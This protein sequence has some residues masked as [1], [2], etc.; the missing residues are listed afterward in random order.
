MFFGREKLVAF[1][2][3]VLDHRSPIV[4][5]HGQRRI[6]KS[7][8]LRQIP[9]KLASDKLSFISF[10]LQDLA[11]SPLSRVLHD[12]AAQVAKQLCLSGA[13]EEPTRA[14]LDRDPSIFA[15]VFLP[16]V[17]KACPDRILVLLLDEFDVLAS[18]S[19]EEAGQHFFPYL[20]TIA[21]KKIVH[22]VAVVGR[23][24]DEVPQL[25]S[26]FNEAPHQ[27]IGLLDDAGARRLIVEPARGVLQYQDD[28]IEAILALSGGH[29]YF[30]QLMCHTVFAAARARDATTVTSS[31]VASAV[32]EALESGEAGLTW[33]RD[34][35]P[36]PERVMFAAACEAQER[37][38]LSEDTVWT[39][40]M[41]LGIVR[42]PE[43]ASALPRLREWKF[44][45]SDTQG[46]L[47]A[48]RSAA[49]TYRV[50]VELVRRWMVKRHPTRWEVAQ[51]ADLHPEHARLVEEAAAK[52]DSDPDTAADLLRQCLKLNPNHFPALFELSELALDLDVPAEAVELYRRAYV[53]DPARARQ[54]FV[55]ALVNLARDSQERDNDEGALRLYNEVLQVDPNHRFARKRLAKMGERTLETQAVRLAKDPFVAGPPV[56]PDELVG[57]SQELARL[58]STLA[59]SGSASIYGLRRIGKTSM[60]KYVLSAEMRAKFG[61]DVADSSIVYLDCA[62]LVPFS[63]E[64]LFRAILEALQIQNAP[65]AAAAW[66]QVGSRHLEESD[67]FDKLQWLL[68]SLRGR[69]IVLLDEM[70]LGLRQI[71]E[72][73]PQA[74]LELTARLR[75][76]TMRDRLS[77]VIATEH[78]P[79]SLWPDEPG[80]VSPWFNT[81]HRIVLG[82][83]QPAEVSAYLSRVGETLNLGS[84][85]LRFL[86]LVAGGHPYLLHSALSVLYSRQSVGTP[87]HAGAATAELLERV[88]IY[89]NRLWADSPPA[90]RAVQLIIALENAGPLK[91][92]RPLDVTTQWPLAIQRL[93]EDMTRRGLVVGTWGRSVRL[94]SILLEWHVLEWLWSADDQA[95]LAL[96]TREPEA[97]AKR[98]H[99]ESATAR[100]FVLPDWVLDAALAVRGIQ[101][102]PSLAEWAEDRIQNDEE[103][104]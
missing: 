66:A 88:K 18:Y 72:R 103:S 9:A 22:I 16:E 28:A 33:F 15:E 37:G 6:G 63:S 2:E 101:D 98:S 96:L 97:I 77:V 51:L 46:S 34:G 32:D 67:S 5:L 42:T 21:A 94:T 40:L 91:A 36:V 47:S 11:Q 8:V 30:T 60:L 41:S 3:D 84:P 80:A 61:L 54:G 4:L 23:R 104:P 76:L 99:P 62:T 89:L 55:Q 75:T 69:A 78:P 95:L 26:L 86:H 49:R 38:R 27:E 24:L 70:E 73:G 39:H 64:R 10:D 83:L 56:S 57:R 17:A 45:S 102:L 25:L 48:S 81:L 14:A 29:P 35:L 65:E 71:Q 87:F 92:A 44:L 53:V 19:R 74:I 100:P 43:L 59:H 50:V 90:E 93:A 79:E 52:R 58:F 85:E 13:V 7:T 68:S 31:D 20:R 1:L 12:L 82:G